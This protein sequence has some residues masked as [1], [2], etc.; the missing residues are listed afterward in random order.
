MS[1]LI[2]NPVHVHPVQ[3][4]GFQPQ[5]SPTETVPSSS[6]TIRPH[7]PPIP[8]D[9][10]QQPPYSRGDV[11]PYASLVHTTGTALT[12]P[13]PTMRFSLDHLS[14]ILSLLFFIPS[15]TSTA[16][17][18][19]LPPAT[20]APQPYP[21]A[22]SYSTPPSSGIIPPTSRVSRNSS[23]RP[24]PIP[25]TP[26]LLPRQPV[27]PTSAAASNTPIHPPPTSKSGMPVK[28]SP[29]R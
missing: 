20:P 4:R 16:T 14:H 15:T 18:P 17:S 11:T 9:N 23:R 26:L 10:Y 13:L 28:S 3:E 7:L 8:P 2:E 29:S 12:N 22:A 27:T 24:P 19:H 6:I 1:Q 25:P 5:R 21:P